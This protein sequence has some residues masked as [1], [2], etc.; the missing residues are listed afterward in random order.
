MYMICERM[1]RMENTMRVKNLIDGLNNG[2]FDESLK[3]I[4]W[5]FSTRNLRTE[6]GRQAFQRFVGTLTEGAEYE[7]I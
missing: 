3:R 6:A 1:L 5:C 7:K 2:R 4:L